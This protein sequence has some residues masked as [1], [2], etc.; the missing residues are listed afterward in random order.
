MRPHVSILPP[1]P[2]PSAV[3]LSIL[4]VGLVVVG[5]ALIA[6]AFVLGGRAARRD[7]ER[8]RGITGLRPEDRP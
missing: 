4:I 5:A 1:V 3:H 7:V 8:W 6:A 2:E